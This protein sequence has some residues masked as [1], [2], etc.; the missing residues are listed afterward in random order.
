LTGYLKSLTGFGTN[1]PAAPRG[2]TKA[3][4]RDDQETESNMSDT[5]T[6]AWT[7]QFNPSPAYKEEQT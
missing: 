4:C 6:A 1:L 3:H 5:T 7:F 2:H